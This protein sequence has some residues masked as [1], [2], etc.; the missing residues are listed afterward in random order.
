MIQVPL[1]HQLEGI[2][3][4]LKREVSDHCGIL[5]DESGLGKKFQ[6]I[7]AIAKNPKPRTLIVVPYASLDPWKEQLVG[8]KF[9]TI[10]LN[11]EK[12]WKSLTEPTIS[13]PIYYVV[14]YQKIQRRPR[15]Q[16]V[17]WDRIIFDDAYIL[18]NTKSRCF[19]TA[20]TLK[21]TIRWLIT[22]DLPVDINAFFTL[23]KVAAQ[24]SL[25][26]RRQL[27]RIVRGPPVPD[28]FKIDATFN[29]VAS[30]LLTRSEP[31]VIYCKSSSEVIAIKEQIDRES[32]CCY[33]E[34]DLETR[35]R[36]L[37]SAYTDKNAILIVCTKGILPQLTLHTFKN[38]IF[39]NSSINERHL[40]RLIRRV[41]CVGQHNVVKVFLLQSI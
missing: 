9:N 33:K 38:I 36:N 13:E 11:N 16:L 3:W 40:E 12:A 2:E 6:M 41:V 26:L 34:Q 19:I 17:D 28:I 25:I 39:V 37:Q 30:K 5:A 22:S 27:Y 23:L 24:E 35:K 21:A 32:Y 20:L 4:I 29:E 7:S 1:K 18:Q 14:N 8:A 31:T 15:L 10:V